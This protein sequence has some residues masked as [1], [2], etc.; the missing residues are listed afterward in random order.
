VGWLLEEPQAGGGDGR[1]TRVVLDL[2]RH[3]DIG[4][5]PTLLVGGVAAP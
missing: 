2:D 3:I 5:P 4:R 1:W